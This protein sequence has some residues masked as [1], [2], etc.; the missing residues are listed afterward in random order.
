MTAAAVIVGLALIVFGARRFLLVLAALAPRRS[1]GDLVYSLL[2]PKIAVVVAARD[3]GPVLPRLLQALDEL[4]YPPEKLSMIVVDDGS[5]DETAQLLE[6]WGHQ[7]GRLVVTL[8]KSI[9][10]AAAINRGIAAAGAVE[11]IVV[12]DADLRPRA[13]CLAELVRPFADPCVGAVSGYMDPVN[14]GTSPVACYA[15]VETWMTQLVTSAGKDRLDLNPPTLGFCAYRRT[16]FE[17]IGGFPAGAVGEDLVAT[18][19]LTKQ[20]WRLRFAPEARAENHV[21]ERLPDYWR[22]HTRWAGNTFD[23]GR[24]ANQS[25]A[26]LALRIETWMMSAG[27]TDRLAL[28]AAAGLAV[29]GTFPIWL[30]LAYLGLRGLEVA[31]AVLKA[32][33]RQR[34]PLFL[35]WTVVFFA[36]DVVASVAATAQYAGRRP[37]S[38]Q[39]PA[40]A[41]TAAPA[42]PLQQ[43]TTASAAPAR[44]TPHD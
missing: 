25:R 39:S 32:G 2:L 14:A 23:A 5:A 40:R 35:F 28:L 30:P 15:A 37:P 7:P 13:D 3:E 20:R 42:P 10:K 26:S 18:V 1:S 8:A 27:Y 36:V 24:T 31:V 21:V 29:I 44:L 6:A 17:E 11:I 38:W 22:Q 33:V 43:T 4:T 12:C 9:G 34:L 19:A 41:P 16:A